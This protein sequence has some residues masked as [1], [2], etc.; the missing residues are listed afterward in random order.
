MRMTEAHTL[1]YPAEACGVFI[2]T[3]SSASPQQ[4][5][6]P[7]TPHFS[8]YYGHATLDGRPVPAGT[9]VRA[10]NPRGDEVG[11]F[12]VTSRGF[13]GYMRV[14]G[15]S[16]GVTP[17]IPGLRPG[18]QVTFKIGDLSAAP[19]SAPLGWQDDKGA[20]RLDLATSVWQTY[21]PMILKS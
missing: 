11:C 16:R 7:Q 18:E 10:F 13:Y 14:Y 1:V 17:P 12:E 15:E 19:L 5:H 20:H 21:L 4:C 9:L 6:V 3:L 8:H 2:A